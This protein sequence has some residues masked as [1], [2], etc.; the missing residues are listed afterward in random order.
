MTVFSHFRGKYGILRHLQFH[1]EA[2]KAS[3]FP[4]NF[5]MSADLPVDSQGQGDTKDHTCCRALLLINTNSHWTE[6]VHV[7]L[8][9]CMYY[10]LRGISKQCFPSSEPWQESRARHPLVMGHSTMGIVFEK[11]SQSSQEMGENL[12][13]Y[14]PK[15]S[16]IH[17]QP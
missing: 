9:V 1:G 14:H 2:E 5:N 8:T 10:I 15:L 11:L 3:W 16:V 6:T 17:M 12:E 7:T 4:M 13:F